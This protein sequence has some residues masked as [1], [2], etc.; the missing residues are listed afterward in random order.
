MNFVRKQ[1]V[2]LV[3]T[4]G[5][6]TANCA[7]DP[8]RSQP[9]V[10][11]LTAVAPT[12]DA[13]ISDA[14][15][16]AA[17]V[18]V[19][20]S[21]GPTAWRPTE[22]PTMD[23]LLNL[24]RSSRPSVSADGR[25][26]AFLSDAPGVLQPYLVTVGAASVPE[27]QWQRLAS[28]DDR[29]H[30]V[31]LVP[32][33]RYALI[34]RDY[35]GDENLQI[36][37]ID[38]RAPTTA[39]VELTTNRRVKNMFGGVSDDGRWVVFTSNE[40]DGTNFDPYIRLV[41]GSQPARKLFDAEGH[42]EVQ[43]IGPGA[44]QILLTHERSN[45]D[46]DVLVADVRS[47]APRNITPHTGDV[48]FQNARFAS[49][50]RGVWVLCDKDREFVNLALVSLT[51]GPPQFVTNEQHDVEMFELSPD[52]N[53]AALVFNVDGRSELRLYDVRNPARVRE[54][55]RPPIERGWVTQ[56]AFAG[57][58]RS[59]ALSLSRGSLSDEVYR[60]DLRAN[61]ASRVTASDQRGVDPSRLVDGEITRIRSFDE[62]E[63]PVIVYRPRGLAEGVRAPV[64]V[65]VHG[66]PESQSALWFNPVM[67]FL[68][69]HGYMVVEPNVRGSTGFGKRYSHMDDA[70]LREDSVR[71]LAAVQAW[72]RTQPGVDPARI[73]VMGGSYGGYMT[74]AAITLYP[75]L[76]AAACDIV[77][78]ANFRTFLERTA[79]YRRALR[80]AEYGSLARDGELLDRV[81]P[82]HRVSQIVTPLMVIHGA[83]DPR[84][85]V[86][87]AEQIVAALRE[88]G[89]VV[90]YLRFENEGHGV[91]RRENRV[92]AYGELVTFFDRVMLQGVVAV[93]ATP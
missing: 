69:G 54:L 16:D 78:I 40:R 42:N 81:S 58:G 3:L 86:H 29:V 90:E 47:G 53:T 49:A 22:G 68:V 14:S 51:G 43:D 88:R 59:M 66:G 64:I 85:P 6:G 74:L 10:Q 84:V 2:A 7:S 15:R 83:N 34:G 44:R 21:L 57:D 63:V 23:Q 28:V 65:N 62:T 35:G 41:D 32:G 38:L 18:A 5:L 82:I 11:T 75:T 72:L 50:N 93:P 9:T 67:Q 26:I 56:L 76:W 48:R 31:K 92:R 52:R 87:E 4:L 33:G 12:D 20:P 30:F 36:L 61:T 8:S 19:L 13:A 70:A 71:D 60:V 46:N 27:A 1:P 73:S 39:P 45:F 79:P 17:T 91:G 55:A 89:R 77:G 80:E 37:R 25:T 24:H